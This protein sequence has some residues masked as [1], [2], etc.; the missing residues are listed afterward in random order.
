MSA[1][2]A[3]SNHQTK[4]GTPLINGK[5]RVKISILRQDCHQIGASSP[6]VAARFTNQFVNPLEYATLIGRALRL[7]KETAKRQS[8]FELKATYTYPTA[9]P[10]YRPAIVFRHTAPPRQ[11]AALSERELEVAR[12]I[13]AGFSNKQIASELGISHNTIAR[14]VANIMRKMPAGNRT[15]AVLNAI[16]QE[17]IPFR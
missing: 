2:S 12:L 16:R 5:K 4:L 3:Q 15:E 7:S 10:T 6:A 11:N 9:G 8:R 17:L 14:H 1:P 13:A